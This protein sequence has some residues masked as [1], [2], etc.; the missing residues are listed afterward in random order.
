[1]KISDIVRLLDCEVLC[2]GDKLDHELHS[3][4]GSDMMSEVLAFVKDESALLTGLI[5]IQVIR[6][7]EMMD[8]QC[9]VFVRGKMPDQ[10]V[11]DAATQKGITLLATK[12]RMYTA[13]GILYSNGLQGGCTV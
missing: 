10:S 9:V 3:A 12:Q 5:N 13:C 6:T 8:I 4:C 7:A 2:C 1:M 11:I